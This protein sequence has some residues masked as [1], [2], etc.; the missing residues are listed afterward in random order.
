M[1]FG[2]GLMAWMRLIGRQ[3]A[4][5]PST[6]DIDYNIIHRRFG[7][8][9]K[10][11]LRKLPDNVEIYLHMYLFL[12]RICHHV[13][14]A[15][16][17]NYSCTASASLSASKSESG[18]NSFGVM[19]FPAISYHKFKWAIVFVD[20]YSGYGWIVNLRSKDA[21]LTATKHFFAMIEE[22][23]SSAAYSA[24]DVCFWW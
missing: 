2:I 3:R 4:A 9:S 19:E 7:H 23:V 20:D 5:N 24:L 15:P 12:Q 8:P 18:V 11:V 16:K 13:L 6:D 1:L 21:A 10:Q 22:T 17:V 14:V